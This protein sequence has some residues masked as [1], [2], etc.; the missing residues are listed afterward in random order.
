M[1]HN[2]TMIAFGH[3][4]A[5]ACL[6]LLL[7]IAS[8][9]AA[10]PLPRLERERCVFR[11]PRGDKIECYTLV[12]AE[13]RSNPKSAEVRLKV[14]RLKAKRPLAADPVIYLAGGPG[15]AP[16]VASN[17]GADPLAEG[18]WWNDTSVIRKRRDVII[19]S[20]RGAG[21]SSPNL[22]CFEPRTSEPARAKRRAVTEPQEREILLRCRADFDRRRID[23]AM[24][25]T[26]ALADDVA[27]LVAAM[28]FKRV[29]LY[30]I[31]YGTRWA[32][33]VMRRHPSIVRAAVLDGVYPPQINGEQDEPEIVRTAFEQ[34]YAEC[35]TD[36]LCRER[37][38]DL[39]G[40]VRA[41]LTKAERTPLE[42][43]L[44]L[45]DGPQPVKLDGARLLLVM[46]HMMRQ[47]EA[48]LVP[49]AVTALRRGDKRLIRQFAEDL[50]EDDGGLLETNAQQFG[51]LFNTIECRETWA[52]VDQ[53]AREQAIQTG[54]IYS[55][56]AQLS[57]LPAFCP[58]WRVPVAPA[59]E[60]QPVTAALPTLLLSGGYDWLTPASWGREAARHLPESRH[61]IFR[62]LGH[63][64]SSQDSCAARLRDEFFDA[65]D[66][67][68]PLPCRA[69]AAPDFASAVE[70]V[71]AMK[72]D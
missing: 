72:N 37:N 51:G 31:S 18:D 3:R 11:P 48:A 5:L 44:Q 47:G 20:Q 28:Q 69:D 19:I 24:Y 30:G 13:N 9:F 40:G 23:L 52:G 55:L 27:D 36:K 1:W 62:A 35:A 12:V 42:L 64:V 71:K 34:L 61:V 22:D 21:G 39:A 56:T 46:L 29:N 4:V 15:D 70:W 59:A 54:G 53:A 68:W 6:L 41:I 7:G 43:V 67:R 63:G 57:K 26:P 49:E 8:A 32:L 14:A 2:R 25:S 58:V 60:R 65:P 17:A 66:P 33:E 50:E 45:E 16:L 38:P 10:P